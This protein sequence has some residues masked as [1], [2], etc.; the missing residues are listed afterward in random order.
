MT[1]RWAAALAWLPSPACKHIYSHRGRGGRDHR[2]SSSFSLVAKLA[3]HDGLIRRR[4]PC[5]PRAGPAPS[6]SMRLISPYSAAMSVP[7]VRN[8]RFCAAL[9]ACAALATGH[10]CRGHPSAAA[11]HELRGGRRRPPGQGSHGTTRYL[12]SFPDGAM[13][14]IPDEDGPDVARAAHA[15][16][17]EALNAG[18]YLF[19][20]G[21]EFQRPSIVATDG[22]V[23][24]GPKPKPGTRRRY[25]NRSSAGRSSPRCPARRVTKRRRLVAMTGQICSVLGK[26]QKPPPRPNGGGGLSCC[27]SRSGLSTLAR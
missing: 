21:L 10:T 8:H 14:H 25:P 18:V 3:F 1:A 19:A 27:G 20:G 4:R 5:P 2:R 26:T 9:L 15:V 23:T 11:G 17:Q 6:A 7:P 16:I 12:I 24:D 13:E 22:T